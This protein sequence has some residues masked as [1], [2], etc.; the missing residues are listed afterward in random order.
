MHR[1]QGHPC[2]C[3]VGSSGGVTSVTAGF[4]PALLQPPHERGCSCIH[5][6][7]LLR[8]GSVASALPLFRKG[9][10]AMV[11][12]CHRHERCVLGTSVNQGLQRR[13]GLCRSA[14]RC[15]VKSA[16][17]RERLRLKVREALQELMAPHRQPLQAERECRCTSLVAFGF[18]HQGSSRPKRRQ[19]HSTPRLPLCSSQHQ[20]IERGRERQR[21]FRVGFLKSKGVQHH[22]RRQL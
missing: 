20:R 8:S 10:N 16:E 21:D 15:Q 18:R 9:W 13:Q 5:A 22:L 3:S 19:K 1:C 12:T 7:R 4:K 11:F 14:E 17:P 6:R 2:H